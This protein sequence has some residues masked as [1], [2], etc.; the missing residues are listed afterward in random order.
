M[1]GIH[2]NNRPQSTS[3]FKHSQYCV[4]ANLVA[5]YLAMYKAM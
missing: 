2:I 5:L 1:I 3:K 4:L